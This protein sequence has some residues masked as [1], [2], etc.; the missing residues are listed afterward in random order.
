MKVRFLAS[1]LVFFGLALALAWLPVVAHSHGP[2][3]KQPCTID[4][5]G[6]PDLLFG[7]AGADVICGHGGADTITAM[8]G[9]DIVRG[10]PGTT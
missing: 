3:T 9:N 1:G 7:T 4:G 10:G 8:G 6:G 2:D 5:T